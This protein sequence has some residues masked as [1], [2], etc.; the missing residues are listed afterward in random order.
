VAFPE[1]SGRLPRIKVC[2][3]LIAY[4]IAALGNGAFVVADGVQWFEFGFL[5]A[6]RVVVNQ[7]DVVQASAVIVEVWSKVVYG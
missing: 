1:R 6:P 5:A 4:G 7:G 2:G 3:C